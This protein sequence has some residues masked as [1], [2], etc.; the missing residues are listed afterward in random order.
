MIITA[1]IDALHG[2]IGRKRGAGAAAAVSMAV[3]AGLF[4]FELKSD[5]ELFFGHWYSRGSA[6]LERYETYA[7]IAGH[8]RR[9]V[10]ENRSIASEEIGIL[11]YYVPNRIWDLY[12]LIHD[13]KTGTIPPHLSDTPDRIP[14]Y[15]TL[16]DPDYVLLNIYRYFSGP[17]FENYE[18]EAE[19]S[20]P[21]FPS[22][23]ALSY[24]LLKR[25]EAAMIV[26]GDV[27]F[28]ER[29]RGRME[30]TGWAIGLEE[31]TGIELRING[32]PVPVAASFESG[33]ANFLGIFGWSP[34]AK[35]AAFRFTF[36]SAGFE[37]GEYAIEAW[38]RGRTRSGIFLRRRL[39]IEN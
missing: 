4:V 27:P 6:F 20:V 22:H 12:L 28:P 34:Y 32:R 3:I 16:M 11:G 17:A 36:D 37:N 29:L 15:L 13:N 7:D 5:Y 14:F 39:M 1:G 31:L 2:F 35:R 19:F 24:M 38:A 18:I 10:P 9:S 33:K 8:V 26:V 23:A 30:L 21:R 25:K